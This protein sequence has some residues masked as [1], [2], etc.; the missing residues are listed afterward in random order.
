MKIRYEF[1]KLILVYGKKTGFD[2]KT[3]NVFFLQ[4]KSDNSC[5]SKLMI[6]FK[7]FRERLPLQMLK[8]FK[9]FHQKLQIK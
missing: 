8:A 4:Y 2:K 6:R 9:W 3:K 7:G 5:N 1:I